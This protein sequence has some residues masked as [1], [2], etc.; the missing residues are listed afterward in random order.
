MEYFTWIEPGVD[1]PALVDDLGPWLG[2]Y[3][4]SQEDPTQTIWVAEKG[5]RYFDKDWVSIR[6]SELDSVE[7]P[8]E[9]LGPLQP[10]VLRLQSGESQPLWVWGQRGKLRDLYE[11]GR[12]LTRVITD[13]RGPDR[14][15]PSLP[16]QLPDA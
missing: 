13:S 16:D 15:Q 4:P 10:L 5:I 3:R 7:Y 8:R 11:V 2:V 12:F 9:K 1:T 6:Y 14:D